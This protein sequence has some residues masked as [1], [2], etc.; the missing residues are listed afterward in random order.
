MK[1]IILVVLLGLL[2]M[3]AS[4]QV[5]Q[6]ASP[7]KPGTF[8]LG[9]HPVLLSGDMAIYLDGRTGIGTGMD[10][11][12]KGGI[13]VGN[14]YL[15]IDIKWLIVERFPVISASAG[16]HIHGNTGLDGTLNITFPLNPS[17][18]LYTGVDADLIFAKDI[19]MSVWVPIG[20]EAS[21][22][23]Q[24]TVILEPGIEVTKYRGH[25]LTGGVRFYF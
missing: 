8:S 9:V 15:G 7:M 6:N 16:L 10:L 22:R 1:K 12:L 25:Y 3:R 14:P 20:L 21:V 17:A 13:G 24:L 19:Y 2:I 5:F 4:A 23:P 18:Y 11:G